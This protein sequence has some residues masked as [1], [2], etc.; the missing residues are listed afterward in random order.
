MLQVLV[1]TLTAGKMS[2]I[3]SDKEFEGEIMKNIAMA[4]LITL[5]SYILIALPLLVC[6]YCK[7]S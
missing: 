1:K 6:T 2:S 5:S 7:C 3:G 4:I